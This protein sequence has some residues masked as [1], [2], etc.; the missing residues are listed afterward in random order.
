MTKQNLQAELVAMCLPE[1]QAKFS[2]V[3]GEETK[4]PNKTYAEL[5][6]M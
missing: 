5:A 3:T 4:A 1:F 2:E 6:V